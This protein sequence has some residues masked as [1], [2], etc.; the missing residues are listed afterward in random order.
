MHTFSFK[1]W[2]IHHNGDY[3][4][5]ARI[6]NTQDEN[7]TILPCEALLQFVSQYI[8]EEKIAAIENSDWKEH[9]K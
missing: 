4:G 5:D 7:E 8:A 2:R 6:V 1:H 9:L 3:S